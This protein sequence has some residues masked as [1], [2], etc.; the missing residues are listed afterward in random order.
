[1]HVL[2][3]ICNGL[4]N[5]TPYFISTLSIKKANHKKKT[6]TKQTKKKLMYTCYNE[7]VST[8]RDARKYLCLTPIFVQV[9]FSCYV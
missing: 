1:M 6:T 8:V 5:R 3:T 4:L 7:N 9:K 2:Y